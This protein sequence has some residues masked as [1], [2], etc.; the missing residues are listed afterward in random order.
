MEERMAEFLATI[1]GVGVLAIL[2][3]MVRHHLKQ[4]EF[5]KRI[6]SAMKRYDLDWDK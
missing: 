6:A 2:I 3:G 4:R 1:L 5:Q